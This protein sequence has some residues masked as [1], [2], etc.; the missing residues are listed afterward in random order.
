MPHLKPIRGSTRYCAGDD[1]FVYRRIADRRSPHYPLKRLGFRSPYGYTTVVICKEGEQTTVLAH[2]LIAEAFIGAKPS[3]VHEVR[4]IN[5]DRMDNRPSNLRWGTRAENEAD[6]I[7]HGTTNRGSR[8]GRAKIDSKSAHEIRAARI[9]GR[10]FQ[11]LADQYG[12][13]YSAVRLIVSG[14]TWRHG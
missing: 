2:I 14:V 4:H 7:A 6:K 10:T 11:S 13:S 8:N 1:G 9:A 3:P 5:G 12:I